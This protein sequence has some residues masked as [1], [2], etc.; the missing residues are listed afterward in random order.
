MPPPPITLPVALVLLIGPRVAYASGAAGVDFALSPLLLCA[1]AALAGSLAYALLARWWPQLPRTKRLCAGLGVAV[2]IAVGYTLALPHVEA[3]AFNEDTEMKRRRSYNRVTLRN[4]LRE[5]ASPF[6]PIACA[7]DD[8]S[9]ARYLNTTVLTDAAD[10]I[11]N[12]AWAC[13][14]FPRARANLPGA[15]KPQSA[16]LIARELHRRRPATPITSSTG[17]PEDLSAQDAY[18]F[19]L[20]DLHVGYRTEFLRTLHQNGLPVLC[21]VGTDGHWGDGLR[22]LENKRLYENP[23]RAWA[24]VQFLQELGVDFTIPLD[25]QAHT[26]LH[27]V[28]TCGEPRLISFALS[29]GLNP[30]QIPKGFGS[31]FRDVPSFK[32][33]LRRIST[34][35][36]CPLSAYSAPKA[37]AELA[38]LNASMP[39]LTAEVINSKSTDPSDRRLS[40]LGEIIASASAADQGPLLNYFVAH[41]A[42]LDQVDSLGFNFL[43]YVSELSPSL[44]TA[45]DKLSDAQLAELLNAGTVPLLEYA[46]KHERTAMVDYLCSRKVP[47]C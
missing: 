14:V 41:G 7:A 3:Y 45:L 35:P 1:V 28:V 18:C 17:E 11:R 15:G 26:M 16:L 29:K 2:C 8:A 42:K 12:V 33:A 36:P 31:S 25:G 37:Q 46:R 6:K 22:E 40:T 44:R 38:A 9:L 21:A 27:L 13:D 20:S 10:T 23:E 30:L 39:A 24:W 32:W 4:R 47:G 5:A 19:L 43:Y 34:A